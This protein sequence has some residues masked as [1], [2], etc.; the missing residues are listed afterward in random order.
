MSL[1]TV[2][3]I[4]S[5]QHHETVSAIL[6]MSVFLIATD[7]VALTALCLSQCSRVGDS[8]VLP[9]AVQR[10]VEY[11]YSRAL[12]FVVYINGYHIA[13]YSAGGYRDAPPP[14]GDAGVSA[15]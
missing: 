11:A 15:V 4:D 3:N 1:D 7:C 5:L 8:G 9:S 10:I 14:S 2:S 13:V 6:L 12:L